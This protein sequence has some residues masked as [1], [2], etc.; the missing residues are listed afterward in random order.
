MSRAI[1][2]L[3]GF[4]EQLDLRLKIWR[5]FPWDVPPQSGL[6]GWYGQRIGFSGNPD[7][8]AK[9]IFLGSDGDAARDMLTWLAEDQHRTRGE[10]VLAIAGASADATPMDAQVEAWLPLLLEELPAAR[11]SKL[12]ARMTNVSRKIIY[13]RALELSDTEKHD[14]D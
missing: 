14:E 11:A 6:E 1:S 4:A 8:D 3:R 13:A 7:P 10:F 2:E 12:L 5:K 9:E